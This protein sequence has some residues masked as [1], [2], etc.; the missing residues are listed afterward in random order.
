MNSIFDLVSL[1]LFMGL[2]ILFLQRSASP[3]PDPVALWRYAAAG[4]G[5]AVAD[6]LGNKGY[7]ILADIG[8]FAVLV[9]SFTML[10]P[11]G[12]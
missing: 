9:F 11:F 4:A 3:K 7:Q 2:A 5:C 1:G 12:K 8:L 6:I 10:K